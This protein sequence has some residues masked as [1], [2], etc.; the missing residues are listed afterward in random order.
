MRND[1]KETH[2]DLKKLLQSKKLNE[3]FPLEVVIIISIHFIYTD[4]F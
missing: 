1:L 3:K 2:N 4:I